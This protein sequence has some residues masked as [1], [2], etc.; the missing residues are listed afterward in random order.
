MCNNLKT[1]HQN[2]IGY[3]GICENCENLHV[4]V[5][6]FMSSICKQGFRAMVNDFQTKRR[7]R[8]RHY[9]NTPTGAKILIRLSENSYISHTPEEFELVIELF[10]QSS[11][12]LSVMEL[13][14]V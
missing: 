1:L 6:N 8:E 5:G 4:E 2:D 10:E 11:H 14:E 12:F 7:F 3:I 13:L 9:V